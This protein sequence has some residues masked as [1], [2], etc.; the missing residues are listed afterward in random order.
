VIGVDGELRIRLGIV[1]RLT[2]KNFVDR[3]GS[4]LN[5]SRSGQVLGERLPNQV[6]EG[7]P[8]CARRL[9]GP[10]MKVSGQQELGAMHV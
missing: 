6:P 7:G 5:A 2:Q 1:E 4:G 3:L 10:P 8:T 9:G